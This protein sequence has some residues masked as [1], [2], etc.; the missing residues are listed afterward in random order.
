MGIRI[1]ANVMTTTVFNTLLDII[2]THS[3]NQA[4]GVWRELSFY[5]CSCVLV[6][7]TGDS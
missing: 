1:G 3:M 7:E 5:S 4:V 6:A 2:T